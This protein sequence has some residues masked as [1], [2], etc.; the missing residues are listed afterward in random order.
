MAATPPRPAELS[1]RDD[2]QGPA[3]VL[4]HGIGGDRLVWNAVATSLRREFRVLAPDLRGHGQSPA[5]PGSEFTLAEMAGDVLHLL[6]EKQ[7]D[8]AHW[9]GLSAGGFLALR[10]T[11]D[12]PERT[13]SLALV[14]SAAY[15]DP[16]GRAVMERWW[17][18]SAEEGPEA[19][20]LRLLKDVYYPDWVEAHMEVVDEV[21]EEVRTR[22][23]GG[24]VA[25]GR[26]LRGFDERN[27]LSGI[28]KPTLIVQAMDDQVMDASHGRILRQSIPGSVIRIF[29]QTGHLI[30]IERPAELAE[31]LTEHLHRAEAQRPA[32]SP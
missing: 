25:W 21:H 6:E 16:H 24:A 8:S 9:V 27:S 3:V 31:A 14:S 1:C 29:A 18:T 28:R 22:D 2:G 17:S 20:A 15:L 19:L 32:G 11:L 30:P 23:Y 5:P 12:H 26:S 13:R 10:L 7:V 4:L